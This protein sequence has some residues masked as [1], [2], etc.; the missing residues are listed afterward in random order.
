MEASVEPPPDKDLAPA[1]HSLSRRRELKEAV[2]KADDPVPAHRS[3][4]FNAKN[5]GQIDSLGRA[6]I[7]DHGSRLDLKLPVQTIHKPAIEQTVCFV[8]HAYVLEPKLLDQPVLID[9]V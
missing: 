2:L 6:V 8:D 7:I 1:S 5:R 4:F 9:P 3:F